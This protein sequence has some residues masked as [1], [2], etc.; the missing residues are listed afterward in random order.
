[1]SLEKQEKSDVIGKFQSHATDTGSTEVQIAFGKGLDI[2]CYLICIL[3]L[4]MQNR[5]K[6]EETT[7]QYTHFRGFGQNYSITL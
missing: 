7:G 6:K 2:G 4:C 5:K 1:M 3:C